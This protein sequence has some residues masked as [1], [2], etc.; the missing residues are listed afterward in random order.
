MSIKVV[1]AINI[2]VCLK[3]AGL[4]NSVIDDLKLCSNIDQSHQSLLLDWS[5]LSHYSLII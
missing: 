3:M 5:I 4:P 2:L 1:V